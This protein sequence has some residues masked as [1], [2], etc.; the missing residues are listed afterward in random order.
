MMIFK[1]ILPILPSG[2]IIY[3]K[4]WFLNLLS[5][6]FLGKFIISILPNTYLSYLNSSGR[7]V[8][9]G[10]I[11]VSS[12]MPFIKGFGNLGNIFGLKLFRYIF[13]FVSFISLFSCQ[14]I[15]QLSQQDREDYKKYPEHILI[16]SGKLEVVRA[17]RIEITDSIRRDMQEDLAQEYLEEQSFLDSF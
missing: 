13:L 4:S 3:L 17:R 15:Y 16:N 2:K 6:N 14:N 10:N 1:F 11:S 9:C 5:K 12:Q 7:L 8:G